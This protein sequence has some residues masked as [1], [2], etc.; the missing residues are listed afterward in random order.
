L[1]IPPPPNIAFQLPRK[2]IFIH[3]IWN[4]K[5][6]VICFATRLYSQKILTILHNLYELFAEVSAIIKENKGFSPMKHK[7]HV[8]NI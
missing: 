1:K 3:G 8:N 6:Y 2:E 4:Y 7:L 5:Y